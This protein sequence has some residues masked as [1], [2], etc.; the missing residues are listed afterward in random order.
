MFYLPK[1]DSSVSVAL[2]NLGSATAY[3]KEKADLPTVAYA[4]TG[5]TNW[6]DKFFVAGAVGAN[7][8]ISDKDSVGGGA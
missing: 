3:G 1:R 2:Q 8:F 7:Y 5:Y 4:G 6:K